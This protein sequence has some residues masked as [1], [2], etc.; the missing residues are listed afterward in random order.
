VTQTNMRSAGM[1]LAEVMALPVSMDIVTAG[2]AHGLGRTKSHAL[3]RNGE[4][5]CAV[6]RVGH[7]Y[8]VT[9]ADLLRSLG[10]EP[11]APGAPEVA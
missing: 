1:T 4:F 3:A 2:R 8:R 10:I 9:R 5:P 11:T 7:T 6:Q